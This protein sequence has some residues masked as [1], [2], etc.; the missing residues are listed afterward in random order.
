MFE[1]GGSG[2]ERNLWLWKVEHRPGIYSPQASLF[3][4][5]GQMGALVTL[6]SVYLQDS[7][8]ASGQLIQHLKEIIC[9]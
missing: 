6:M 9:L 4:F 3:W 5:A 1:E 8:E 2:S 7:L